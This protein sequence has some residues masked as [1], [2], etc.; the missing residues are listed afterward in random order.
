MTSCRLL[1][2]IALFISVRLAQAALPFTSETI[3]WEEEVSSHDGSVLLVRRT[4]TYGPDEFGR[5]GRGALK[6]QTLS[7]SSKGVRVA[8]S[9]E[10]KWPIHYLPDI[11]DLV[12]GNPVIVL[13]VHRFGPCKK[14]GFPQVGM[15]GFMYRNKR[16]ET[17]SA[18]RLPKTLKVNL[19]RSTHAL[20]YWSE[21][22]GRRIGEAERKELQGG[23][24]GPRQADSIEAAGKFYSGIEDSCS[25]IQPLPDLRLDEA[26]ERNI[27]AGSNARPVEAGIAET[28]QTPEQVSAS[29]YAKARGRWT[30]HGYLSASCKEI[31]KA[32]EP[33][34]NYDANGGWQ[35]VGHLLITRDDT[36]IPLQQS[37]LP[38]Y[39]APL[40]LAQVAC[41]DTTIYAIRRGNKNSL[42]VHRFKHSGEVIDALSVSLPDTEKV[43]PGT[44]WGDLWDVAIAQGLL[45]FAIAN[46]TYPSLA[47][48]GGTVSGK[49]T[50]TVKLQ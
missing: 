32:I 30:G 16:W 6:K 17:V 11:F 12:E 36:K 22:K 35:L 13:P 40:E 21:Y 39:R 37:N 18:A 5:S 4:V 45:T 44:S 1:I 28:T 47:N 7:F 33:L 10:D 14:Y 19:L 25:R 41:D 9:S 49:Q 27:Q 34:R 2:A 42:L 29:G 3:S 24:W 20:Q 48:H 31:V 26:Q 43:L 23:T 38:K 50:Y 46:Y 8:W 15:I